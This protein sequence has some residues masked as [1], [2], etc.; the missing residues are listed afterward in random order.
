V[1]FV[2][3]AVVGAAVGA[4][5]VWFGIAL[6]VMNGPPAM[7]Q[8]TKLLAPISDRM[9]C[10]A[11]ATATLSEESDLGSNNKYGGKVR[12]T[13][14]QGT[15]TLSLKVDRSA[16]RLLVLSGA[17]VRIGTI[18]PEAMTIV[19]DDEHALVAIQVTSLPRANVIVVRIDRKTGNAVW[20]KIGDILGV[21]IGYVHYLEC[22]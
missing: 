1:K 2:V 22:R 21:Q 12:V 19:R 20:G 6:G 10:K 14:M 9:G 4:A 8:Y 11:V 17:D 13:A 3:V 7:F 16:Q 5:L 18:E 15:D